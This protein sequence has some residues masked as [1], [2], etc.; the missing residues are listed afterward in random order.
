MCIKNHKI[1]ILFW[2]G[3]VIPYIFALFIVILT[4]VPAGQV[5]Y[6]LEKQRWDGKWFQL[7][8]NSCGRQ[9]EDTKWKYNFNLSFIGL[10]AKQKAG[11]VRTSGLSSEQKINLTWFPD[12]RAKNRKRTTGVQWCEYGPDTKENTGVQTEGKNRG[13]NKRQW[14]QARKT[15]QKKNIGKWDTVQG[16]DR[17]PSYGGKT[18]CSARP[19]SDPRAP[20]VAQTKPDSWGCLGDCLGES[21]GGEDGV[22]MVKGERLFPRM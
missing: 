4:I 3:Y 19:E 7:S 5:F 2:F 10:S 20:D 12:T 16:T 14:H 9:D 6:S 8:C 15:V 21:G 18:R 11:H 1:K 22:V 13:K 17:A